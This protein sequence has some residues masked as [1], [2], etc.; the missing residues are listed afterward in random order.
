MKKLLFVFALLLAVSVNAQEKKTFKGAME[1]AGLTQEE[2]T[3]ALVINKEKQAK[4]KEIKKSDL[5]KEEKKAKIKAVRQESNKK[6]KAVVGKE[7]LKALNQY[8]KKK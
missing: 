5:S 8:W 4:L 1:H 7:K 6:I 2:K 3:Q